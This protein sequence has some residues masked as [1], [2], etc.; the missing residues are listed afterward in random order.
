MSPT[1]STARKETEMSERAMI[2]IDEHGRRV[3]ECVRALCEATRALLECELAYKAHP[4]SSI[5]HSR[6][7]GEEAL[8]AIGVT[9]HQTR[10]WMTEPAMTANKPSFQ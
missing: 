3:N 6:K 4:E 2:Q 1:A 7:R 9:W 5:T 10:G 8:A